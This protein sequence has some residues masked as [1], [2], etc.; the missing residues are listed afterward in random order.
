MRERKKNGM[1]EMMK[2]KKRA[3]SLAIL[4][5]VGMS[6]GCLS[7]VSS[8]SDDLV[9]NPVDSLVIAFEVKDTYLSLIHI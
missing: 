4:M 5:V 8:T 7:D 2:N 1:I 9:E 6:A 3:I